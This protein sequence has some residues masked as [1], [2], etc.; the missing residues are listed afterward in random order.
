MTTT[1]RGVERDLRPGAVFGLSTSLPPHDRIQT[2]EDRRANARNAPVGALPG[3][4]LL[5]PLSELDL[6]SQHVGDNE[7]RLP[8]FNERTSPAL[9]RRSVV[10][11]ELLDQADD[12]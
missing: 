10:P 6:F 12:G 9:G 4:G 1:G 11:N 5:I 8:E 3:A 7:I 2:R